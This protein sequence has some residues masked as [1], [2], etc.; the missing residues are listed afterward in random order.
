MSKKRFMVAM[1]MMAMATAHA[2]GVAQADDAYEKCIAASNDSNQA[3][4][5]CGE[6]YVRREKR[7]LDKVWADFIRDQEGR[8]KTD[9]LAEQKAWRKFSQVACAFYANG[10]LGR[11]G[12]VLSYPA[13][14]A[15]LYAERARTLKAY[16]EGPE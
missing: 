14:K 16:Q 4:L 10:D 2:I 1:A 13:C 7:Q 15:R 3:W 11:E 12:Q 9:L 6:D 8:T 5:R